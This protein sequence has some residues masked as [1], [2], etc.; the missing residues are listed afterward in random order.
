MPEASPKVSI[1]V[2]TKDR[3]AL[4]RETIGSVTR[5]TYAHWELIIVD[6]RSSDGTAEMV[7]ELARDDAR[8][9]F[10]AL[11]HSKTGAPAARNQGLREASGELVVFLDS[12]DLLAESC[13]ARR[14]DV[15]SAHSELDF[16]IFPCMVFQE[17]PGDLKL[18]FNA[19][20]GEDD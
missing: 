5:Q 13:L 7:R 17:Q 3:R 6:D 18:L 2:P 16:A 4:L 20:N 11:E 10:L 14:A 15:M 12:D 19:D 9:R 1:I 8:I